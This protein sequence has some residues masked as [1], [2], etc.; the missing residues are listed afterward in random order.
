M[1]DDVQYII[2]EESYA[3]SHSQE[4][5]ID[6]FIPASTV[7]D[8]ALLFIHGGGWMGGDKSQWHSVAAHFASRGY[9]TAT[10]GYRLAPQHRFP[11]Q[12]EDVRLAM[13]H[14]QRQ[15]GRFPY[16]ADR[17]VVIGSSAGAHLSL[18]LAT[19]APSHTIGASPALQIE[20][21]RPMGLVCY[22][23]VTSMKLEREFIREFL[24]GS[25]DDHPQAY[26]QASPV[27]RISGGEPP[28]LVL[29]GEADETTP[30]EMS[31]ELVDK[32]R[33]Y[34]GYAELHTFAG[35]GHGFGYGITT[36]PQIQ[37]LELIDFFLS[38]F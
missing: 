24:G 22:C 1:E 16:G 30:V 25:R 21:T 37:C 35:I 32:W 3:L 26:L 8:I 13:Q 14:V 23:P 10:I 15:A 5:Q 27:E 29:Q 36:E 38:Q 6:F 11:A 9:S 7:Q 4:R 2:I 33:Q 18:M 28:I 34:G 12:I 19:I 17:I 20:D 31:Q